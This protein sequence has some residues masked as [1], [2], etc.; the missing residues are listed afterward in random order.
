MKK[1]K[2]LFFNIMYTVGSN[3]LTLLVST[4]VTLFLP[5]LLGIESY[6]YFQLYLFYVSYVGFLH[7]GWCDGIYLK[8]GGEDYEK[9]DKSKF[10]GQFYA[11]L[12]SQTVITILFIAGILLFAKSSAEKEFVLL[13]TT[14]NIVVL[15]MRTF[16]TFI[17]QATNRMKDFSVITIIDRLI[18]IVI[19]LGLLVM[20]V[21]KFEYY[22]LSDLVGKIFSLLISLLKIKGIVFP[23]KSRI[24]WDNSESIDNIRV[25][26]NLMFANIASTLILGIV[27]FG[28]QT[29]WSVAIFGKIS[30]TLS[31]S[32]ML[33]VFVNAVSL[34]IF[35]LL[36]RVNEREY[37]KIYPIV[38]S[39]IMPLVLVALLCYYPLNI[40]LTNWLPDYADSLKY[41]AIVFPMV[42][43]ESKV[44]LLTNTYLKVLR[45]ERQIF[46]VNLLSAILSL[47]STL[48]FVFA[49]KDLF[50]SMLSIVILLAFR[51]SYAEIILARYIKITIYQDMLLEFLLVGIFIITSWNLGMAVGGIIYSISLGFY[52]ILKKNNFKEIRELIKTQK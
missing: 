13:A 28:I 4:I 31:I 47:I 16:S 40:I 2:T 15:N 36:K 33:M 6:G 8:Y 22:I 38:R 9:L 10:S 17:L 26:I 11:L 18:Y 51:S 49:L 44:S 14:I 12:I 5:K 3:L 30:L 32:N 45:K 1:F 24:L 37:A 35:P 48:L 27:R 41:M 21:D 42:V 46:Q 39:I 29:Q 34:A 52:L 19:V 7:F 25:G 50:L 20:R 43:F 23:K